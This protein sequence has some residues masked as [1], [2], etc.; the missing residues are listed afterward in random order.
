M[1]RVR[2]Y[3]EEI[4]KRSMGIIDLSTSALTDR[5]LIASTGKG[6][7][8]KQEEVTVKA[9]G[10]AIERALN[11]ALWFQKQDDCKIVL[12]TGEVGAVDDVE[13]DGEESAR[14]RRAPVLE[15]GITLR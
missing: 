2:N 10:R 15:V 1:K 4:D 3:L 14:V 12:R 9:T 7:E 6:R 8:G 11:V 13:I 5:E